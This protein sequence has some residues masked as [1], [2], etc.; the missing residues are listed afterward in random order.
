MLRVLPGSACVDI[1]TKNAAVSIPVSYSHENSLLGYECNHELREIR[2]DILAQ[3]VPRPVQSR[4]KSLDSL[5]NYI[6]D[7]KDAYESFWVY[8]DRDTDI[9][10]AIPG[11]RYTLATVSDGN[12][13][14]EIIYI[15]GLNSDNTL[16]QPFTIKGQLSP[17]F[18]PT[19][20]IFGGT[21]TTDV[22]QI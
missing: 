19:I 4:F 9:S 1:G 12:G 8:L 16:W 11:G 2:N 6:A 17:R 10:K 5:R 7:S 15:D 13:S 14:Y 20:S 22:K 21:T 18:L 3:R